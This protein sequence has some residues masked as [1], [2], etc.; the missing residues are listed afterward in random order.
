MI[1]LRWCLLW[2]PQRYCG[3]CHPPKIWFCCWNWCHT[4]TKRGWKGLLLTKWGFLGRTGGLVSM[5]KNGLREQGRALT[6]LLLWLGNGARIKVPSC[7]WDFH[8]WTSCWPQGRNP[9]VFLPA[10]PASG[11]KGKRRSGAQKLSVAKYKNWSQTL[12]YKV[13][14]CF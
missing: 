7:A 1:T 5:Y 8:V 11:E 12:Y 9:W 10:C 2:L 14:L 13:K 3:L 6:W 4:C